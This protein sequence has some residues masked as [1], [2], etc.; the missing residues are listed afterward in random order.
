MSNNFY[1]RTVTINDPEGI[2]ERPSGAIALLARE[3]LGRVELDYEG[4]TVNAKNDM[5][6]QSLGGLYEH[7]ITVRVS[8][9]HDKA[10]KTL[11]KLTELI[12]SEE[13]TSSSTLLLT[14]NQV[15]RSN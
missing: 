5:F 6:V 8:P 2:H 4:M 9:E 14:A 1:E 13:M 11:D 15:L 12:S 10:Q 7:S 3:Y